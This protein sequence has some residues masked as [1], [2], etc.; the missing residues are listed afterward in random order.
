MSWSS[1]PRASDGV[2]SPSSRRFTL[3]TYVLTR[4]IVVLRRTR[5]IQCL[6]VCGGRG[7]LSRSCGRPADGE[8][9]YLGHS[10]QQERRAHQGTDAP[11][12]PNKTG[13]KRRKH[14]S[15]LLTQS[16]TADA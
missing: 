15:C 7:N 1:V 3:A 9:I 5:K 11:G 10:S 8:G 2:A 16:H 14:S 4:R 6:F 13:D 12:A